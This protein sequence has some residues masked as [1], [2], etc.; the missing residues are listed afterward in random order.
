MLNHKFFDSSQENQNH[1]LGDRC[2][3]QQKGAVPVWVVTDLTGQIIL[4]NKATAQSEWVVTGGRITINRMFQASTAMLVLGVE[5]LDFDKPYPELPKNVARSPKDD[6]VTEVKEGESRR[7]IWKTA[8][9]DPKLNYPLDKNDEIAIWCGYI[10]GI[11]EVTIKDLEDNKLIR[12]FVGVIDTLTCSGTPTQGVTMIIQCRDRLKYLMDSIGTFNTADFDPL[13]PGA[14]SSWDF[15]TAKPSDDA[16]SG[17]EVTISRADVIIEIARRCIGHLGGSRSL[18]NLAGVCDS[19]CGSRIHFGF[20][21]QYTQETEPSADFQNMYDLTNVNNSYI[22]YRLQPNSAVSTLPQSGTP[23][24]STTPEAAGTNSDSTNPTTPAPV[25][26][27]TDKN[28]YVPFIGGKTRIPKKDMVLQPDLTFNIV[29]GRLPYR[30]KGMDASAIGSAQGITDRVPA[31]FIKFLSFQEPWPTEFFCDSRS[32]E[33]WYAPRGL[34]IS[35][36]V[37]PKRFYRTYFFRN[38]PDGAIDH[39]IGTSKEFV[40][41]YSDQFKKSEEKV[42]ALASGA[43]AGDISLGDATNGIKGIKPDNSDLLIVVS[44]GVEGETSISVLKEKATNWIEWGNNANQKVVVDLFEVY[45]RDV[46]K[47]SDIWNWRGNSTRFSTWLDAV[48]AKLK[49]T[50]SSA[51]PTPPNN[52]A[53]ATP[54]ELITQPTRD[55]GNAIHSAQAA[56]LYRE[57]SSSINWRSNI[58]VINQPTNDLTV[59]NAVHL[60]LNPPWLAGRNYA[61]SYFQA[62]DTTIGN[63]R[64]ELVSV[65]MAYARIFSKELKAATLHITGDPSIVPGEAVQVIGSPM[66]PEVLGNE[67]TTRGTWKWDRQAVVDYVAAYRDLYT[68]RL[69]AHKRNDVTPK[70]NS[71]A[72]TPEV[73]TQTPNTVTSTPSIPADKSAQLRAKVNEIFTYKGPNNGPNYNDGVALIRQEAVAAGVPANVIDLG[74]IEVEKIYQQVVAANKAG[75]GHEESIRRWATYYPKMAEVFMA[76][77]DGQSLP[78]TTT[79]TPSTATTP[80]EV[81]GNMSKTFDNVQV[82]KNIERLAQAQLMCPAVYGQ[83]STDAPVKDKGAFE[84]VP[85]VIGNVVQSLPG[86]QGVDKTPETEEEKKKALEQGIKNTSLNTISFPEDPKSIWRVEAVIDK[87][88]ED[89]SGS[90]YRTELALLAPF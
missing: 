77:I 57:E 66:H 17:R 31:E 86:G 21:S 65:A 26:D 41:K 29:T 90:G 78:T 53:I 60:K 37:D 75:S 83:E 79:T 14:A 22:G 5:Q 10:E 13:K 70:V 71:D 11:R 67:A 12:R 47:K 76:V 87:F 73:P 50:P 72:T 45:D 7:A 9:E 6:T 36:L 68:S 39:I 58:I 46:N 51:V 80:Q 3:Q 85:D 18:K 52:S 23:D 61:C 30:V 25:S 28:K 8:T 15:A 34:D 55:F 69:E 43:S 32:G 56:L 89:Q 35:G 33:Y 16:Q 20:L 59:Q 40:D 49:A 82:I 74:L 2:H 19:V 48:V 84:S 38:A 42:A 4:G 44:N 54:T 27:V 64:A 62:T 81:L 63:N 1:L 24:T 88:N